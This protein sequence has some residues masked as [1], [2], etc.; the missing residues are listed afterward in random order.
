M[1]TTNIS[2]PTFGGFYCSRWYDSDNLNYELQEFEGNLEH[3]CTLEHLDD[4]GV[5]N[6]Y[7]TD[8]CKAYTER[9]QEMLQDMGLQIRLNYRK[10]WSPREYNFKTDRI[11]ADI[12][13]DDDYD[14]SGHLQVFMDKYRNKL[15]DLIHKCHTSC[16]G[17]ESWMDNDFE[18]W[19]TRMGQVGMEYND[20]IYL[21]YLLAY[22]LMCDQQVDG[23]HEIDEICYGYITEW[24]GIWLGAY[25][26]PQSD[27][28]KEE[29]EKYLA[30][31]EYK[32]MLERDQLS[33][34]FTY[35]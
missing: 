5:S 31:V 1:K 13:W 29:Y 8:I 23:L 30:K 4:W 3:G 25:L 10:M 18:S 21:S 6:D 19:Y 28:A 26:E 27:E 11:Y 2:L 17:F 16:Y 20:D 22:L 33:F 32:H 34:N 35:A 14:L 15:T 7:F 24:T 9:I 12:S